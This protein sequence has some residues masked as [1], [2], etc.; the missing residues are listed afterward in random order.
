[1]LKAAP[2]SKQPTGASQVLTSLPSGADAISVVSVSASGPIPDVRLPIGSKRIATGVAQLRGTG[3]VVS[4]SLERSEAGLDNN[5]ITKRGEVA[6]PVAR[7]L[8]VIAVTAFLHSH[9]TSSEG[10]SRKLRLLPILAYVRMTPDNNDNK[11]TTRAREGALRANRYHVIDVIAPLALACRPTT[12]FSQFPGGRP[13]RSF[14]LAMNGTAML[15]NTDQGLA[16]TSWS[17]RQALQ[18]AVGAHLMRPGPSSVR[19]ASFLCTTS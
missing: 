4:L 17:A 10:N 1:V 5:P 7:H 12:I 8:L 2:M 14:R 9:G 6:E 19:T 16:P 18:E 11:I 15:A 13:Y 3:A